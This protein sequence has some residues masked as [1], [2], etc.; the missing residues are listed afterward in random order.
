MLIKWAA[1]AIIL[2]KS[3][4]LNDLLPFKEVEMPCTTDLHNIHIEALPWLARR[5][6]DLLVKKP[7]QNEAIWL[8]AQL[9]IRQHGADAPVAARRSASKLHLE[10]I[11]RGTWRE[12]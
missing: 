4:W 9:L 3:L 1:R 6:E 2:P 10:Q 8:V 11:G 7:R 12:R 5:S